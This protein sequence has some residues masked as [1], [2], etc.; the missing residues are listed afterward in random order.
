MKDFVDLEMSVDDL[1]EVLTMAGLEVE[2]R[3]PLGGSLQDVVAGKIVSV[4][5]HPS[6]EKALF[7]CDVDSGHGIFQV[8]C[9]APNVEVGMVAPIALPGATL[10]GGLKVK[11]SRIRGEMSV[12]MLLAEDEMGLTDDHMGLMVLPADLAPGASVVDALCLDDS[13]FEIAITPNRADCAS[14]IGI[15]RE[16]AALTG[17]SLRRPHIR[18]K[19]GDRPINSL[20]SVTINDPGGCPRY[21]AGMVLGVELKPSPFWI[22]YRLFISGIR[23]IS[24]VV[25]VTNYVLLELGQPLHAFDYDR[26][27]ENR[28][29][30]RRAKKGESFTTLDGKTHSLNSENLLICDAQRAVALAGI[31][32]GLNSEIYQGSKNVLVESAFFD[33]VTIRRGSKALGISTEASYRFERGI[34][35]EGVV[36]ALKRSLMLM[37]DLAG[38]EVVNGIIDN[39]PSPH[40]RPLIEFSA[41]KTNRFLGTT[42]SG[43]TMAR[44]L[45]ALGME[46]ERE[47]E[48]TFQVKPPAFRVDITRDWDLMEEIARLEGYQRIPVTFPPIRASEELDPPEIFL[49]DKV[50]ALMVEMGFAE[51]IS[52]SFISPECADRLQTPKE[53]PVRSFVG[54]LNPLT[55]EQSVMRTT[56][57]PGL[58]AALGTNF[59]YGEKDLKCFEWGRLFLAQ[60][61]EQ[62]PGEKYAFAAVMSGLAIRKTWHSEE[63]PV[64]F[65]DIKGALEG[66]LDG[67]GLSSCAFKR[68]QTPPWYRPQAAALVTLKGIVLGTVGELAKEV[69]KSFDLDETRVFAF[70]LDG[71]L[72]LDHAFPE[73]FFKPL[74]K[75]PAAIRDVSLVVGKDVE[76]DGIQKIIER[77]GGELLESVSLFDLYEGGKIGPAEKALAF[78]ICYRS[79]ETTL[80]GRDINVLHERIIGKLGKETGA[81]LR[82]S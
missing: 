56:L 58:M 77:E 46:V 31:M 44:Y 34:D 50:R 52:Y 74:A 8:V 55:V 69:V 10:P 78:R 70:E 65:Y 14:V 11:E 67:L 32:G 38:G 53:S 73:T 39:Y 42:L 13:A 22:R 2:S 16:I 6:S 71:S 35:I 59:A 17:Q 4:R 37:S 48:N 7:L 76:C 49:G 72:L 23:A 75:F 15:A 3:E 12:G 68:G 1:G 9:G 63:R 60:G 36:A 62:L 29:V 61:G 79:K 20:T 82:E 33:P 54:L 51:V 19:E 21:A 47:D 66:F 57:I 64:D 40:H 26:L 41:D 5:S 30:V 45:S 80:E 18:F 24:N 28:I 27:V 25:D 81:R 43:G